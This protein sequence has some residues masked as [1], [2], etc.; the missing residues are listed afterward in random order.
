[1]R[2]FP[3]RCRLFNDYPMLLNPFARAATSALPM[4][5]HSRRY[6]NLHTFDSSRVHS[7]WGI[8]CSVNNSS[9]C[10]NFFNALAIVLNPL[11]SFL[12]LTF[13]NLPNLYQQCYQQWLNGGCTKYVKA[14]CW[15]SSSRCW[16]G[17]LLL[18]KSSGMWHVAC[19]RLLSCSWQLA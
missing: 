17:A 4:L 7:R 2:Q 15:Y 9:N 19:K 18:C 5:S 13:D 11:L 12:T 14:S 6:F 16:L 8:D 10:V 1:M 3:D